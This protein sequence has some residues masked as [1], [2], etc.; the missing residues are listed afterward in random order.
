MQS[1]GTLLSRHRILDPYYRIHHNPGFL[2]DAVDFRLTEW[3]NEPRRLGRQLLRS[4]RKVL[5][6]TL[7]MLSRFVYR[8]ITLCW[9]S[10][11]FLVS[12]LAHL[13]R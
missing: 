1:R 3:A 11:Y 10:A 12:R 5:H 8:T 7:R 13:I 2:E 4:F 6:A 9:F